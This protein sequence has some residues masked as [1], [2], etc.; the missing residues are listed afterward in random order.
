MYYNPNI[1]ICIILA[2]IFTFAGIYLARRFKTSTPLKRRLVGFILAAVS[3]PGWIMIFNGMWWRFYFTFY[4]E[5][6]SIDHVEVLS[7]MIVPFMSYILALK[8]FENKINWRIYRK[9]CF[10]VTYIAI[11]TQFLIPV[12][13]P[14]S[15]GQSLENRWDG[16]ICLQTTP[17]TCA[18]SAL[19]TVFKYYGIEKTQEEITKNVYTS[20]QGTEDY[21]TARYAR[22][23]GLTVELL[24]N[25]E[26]KDIPV[27]SII[28]IKVG[29]ILHAVAVVGHK[30]GK[31]LLIADPLRGMEQRQY[32]T[33]TDYWK[34]NKCVMHFKKKQ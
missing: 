10:A 5:L 16:K 32:S 19:A 17:Y 2:G 26:A 24:E 7:S 31:Y 29:D 4:V 8:P 30:D 20:V 1:F 28:A 15:V 23:N 13:M 11:L 3:I 14:V 21:Y 27:P 18:P 22:Q 6:F 34:Y 25:V 9:Y 33:M 12:V